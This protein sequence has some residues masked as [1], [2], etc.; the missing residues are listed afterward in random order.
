MTEIYL[1]GKRATWRVR[2]AWVCSILMAASMAASGAE[3]S[4]QPPA[5]QP[6][7]TAVYKAYELSFQYRSS[8]QFYDCFELE[9]RVAHFLLA[10]GARDDIDV[11]ALSCNEQLSVEDPFADPMSNRLGH[12]GWNRT[13]PSLRSSFDNDRR[14]TATLRI[15]VMMPVE[16]TPKVLAEI[17]KDRARRELVSRVTRNPAAALNDPIVFAARRE[18]VALSNRTVRMQPKDCELLD[19]FSF[20]VLRR[21]DMRVTSKRSICSSRQPSRIPPELTAEVLL[22]TGALMPLPNPE[23]S[24]APKPANDSAPET[25]PETAEPGAATPPEGTEQT[26]SATPPR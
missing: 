18:Q 16:V 24:A 1:S 4:G 10:L 12:D 26:G 2:G 7:I 8:N 20:Q 6:P 15:R 5:G 25:A 13:D 11:D 22:P 21:L 9:Q 14:Q 17:D 19:Q 23:K 3:P